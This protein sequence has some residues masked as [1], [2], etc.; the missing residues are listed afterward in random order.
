MARECQTIFAQQA[1]REVQGMT[2]SGPHLFLRYGPIVSVSS[3]GHGTTLYT[4]YR[5]ESA[6]AGML[7]RREGWRLWGCSAE[8]WDHRLCRRLHSP[9]TIDTA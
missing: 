1:Y 5:V 2:Y 3:V 8:E 4:D 6:E 9:S 7:Y